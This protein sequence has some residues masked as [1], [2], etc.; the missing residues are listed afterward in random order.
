MQG[1]LRSACKLATLLEREVFSADAWLD[2]ISFARDEACISAMV[3]FNSALAFSNSMSLIRMGSC[4]FELGE[5]TLRLKKLGC[6]Y[7]VGCELKPG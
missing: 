2:E 4:S 5:S 3:V 7:D 6:G 1:A